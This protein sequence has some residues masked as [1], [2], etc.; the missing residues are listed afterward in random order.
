MVYQTYKIQREHIYECDTI[1]E[2]RLPNQWPTWTSDPLHRQARSLYVLDAVIIVTNT[3]GFWRGIISTTL[4]W[5]Q[6]HYNT[7]LATCGPPVKC[8]RV[9]PARAAW[10]VFRY[11]F[12]FFK[13]FFF[14]LFDAGN[15]IATRKYTGCSA[16]SE[17]YANAIIRREAAT[18][19]RTRDGEFT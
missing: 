18:K 11:I 14:L 12:M 19:H 3:L 6:R 4:S 17:S 9:D 16:S 5:W 2:L 1:A 15:E 8:A 13:R 10:R 7:F